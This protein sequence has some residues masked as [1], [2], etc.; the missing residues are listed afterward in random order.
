MTF[1]VQDLLDLP[2]L[3]AAR[4]EVLVGS[5]LDRRPVRWIHSSEIYEIWPLLKGGEALLTTGLGLVGSSTSA[6]EVYVR[7][8]AEKDVAVLMLELGRTFPR[9]PHQLVEAATDCGLPVVVLHGVVPF[10]EVTETVHPLLLAGEVDRLRL[11]ERTSATLNQALLAGRG[12]NELLTTVAAICE[13]PVGLYARDGALLAGADV[14]ARDGFPVSVGPGPWATLVVAAGETPELR[15]LAEMCAASVGIRLAH[16]HRLVPS[17]PSAAASLLRDLAARRRL[18]DAEVTER[19]GALGLTRR[20]GSGAVGLAVTI[21]TPA[22]TAA[23]VHTVAEVARSVFGAAI[24]GEVDDELLAATMLPRP[25]VRRL[26]EEF[27]EELDR[28]LRSRLGGTVVRV[29]AGPAVQTTAEL[30]RSVPAAVDAAALAARLG[31]ASRVVLAGDLAVYDILSAVGDDELE[32]FVAEQLGPLL[33]RDARTG[34]DLVPTLDAYL[35]SG[36]SKT[37]AAAALG[38]R[39]QTLYGRLERISRLLGGLDLEDRQRRTAL[40]LG[41][42]AWRLRSSAAARRPVR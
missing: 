8:L 34:S 20:T 16:E 5:G 33:E 15:Q 6:I 23:V 40:D 22:S 27:H 12:L 17:R 14:A 30:A 10:I 35:E 1:T 28:T 24:V 42:A 39:R 18:P 4:P 7:A 37:A 31:L 2:V 26:L 38:V 41:L 21:S 32:R 29:V 19:A 36:L 9:P 25:D 13:A 3:K 11:V